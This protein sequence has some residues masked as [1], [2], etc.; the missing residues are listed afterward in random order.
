ME[1]IP[2]LITLYLIGAVGLFA[3]FM[4]KYHQDRP[5]YTWTGTYTL[6]QVYLIGIGVIAFLMLVGWWAAVMLT[7]YDTAR[8]IIKGEH[9]WN[10]LR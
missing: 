9:K 1:L 10:K 4:V 3:I 5:W 6:K 7:I 8:S 2:F